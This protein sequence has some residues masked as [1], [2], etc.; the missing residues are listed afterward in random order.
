MANTAN[1]QLYVGRLTRD[2]KELIIATAA[3]EGKSVGHWARDV[4]VSRSL[5]QLRQRMSAA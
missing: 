3:A 5:Q 1:E 2:E 4:L